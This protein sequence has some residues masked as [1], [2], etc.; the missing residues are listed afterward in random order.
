MRRFSVIALGALIA[1]ADVPWDPG[2]ADAAQRAKPR[3]ETPGP[4]H[5]FGA[6][7]Q[8]EKVSA[9]FT[10]RNSGSGDLVL[11]TPEISGAGVATVR[12][13]GRIAAGRT[14]DVAV[15]IDT[16]VLSG[17]VRMGVAFATNDP[18]RP[19]VELSVKG[20]VKPLVEVVPPSA[21]SIVAFRSDPAEG[22]VTIVNNDDVPLRITGVDPGSGLFRA[23]LGTVT[24]GAAYRLRIVSSAAAPPGRHEGRVVVRTDNRRAPELPVVVK[25]LVRDRVYASPDEI[26]F[27]KV[28]R[29]DLSQ[30]TKPV[31]PRTQSVLVRRRAG[32]GLR[33]EID[34]AVPFVRVVAGPA[35]DNT[36]CRLDVV[37]VPENLAPGKSDGTLRVRTNDPEFPL[38]AIP[39]RV[40]VI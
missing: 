27:G 30:A 25:L 37:L 21:V 9:V 34:G 17:D 11:G 24:E 32:D 14:G 26:D 31:A 19:R 12:M 15:T 23:E 18:D 22:A 7:R 10:I 4:V 28:R 13:R 35:A 20:R 8:G 33:V 6:A 16:N 1:A 36:A 29:E 39:I 3:V 38:V 5:D 2:S 40:E